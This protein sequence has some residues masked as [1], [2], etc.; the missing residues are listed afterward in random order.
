MS[1]NVRMHITLMHRA[2]TRAKNGLCESRRG[3]SMGQEVA[4]LQSK[5]EQCSACLQLKAALTRYGERK[6][7]TAKCQ[8]CV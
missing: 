8:Y 2:F 5:G 1:M 7:S 6:H 4:L 3:P